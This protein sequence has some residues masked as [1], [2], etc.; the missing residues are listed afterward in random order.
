M[1]TFIYRKLKHLLFHLRFLTP[2]PPSAVP[3]SLPLV[4]IP[5]PPASSS[6]SPAVVAVPIVVEPVVKVP[7]P[8][9]HAPA[10]L[11]VA[12]PCPPS[13]EGPEL[14]C[15]AVDAR[16]LAL[17]GRAGGQAPA[18]A[19]V[20]AVEVGVDVGALGQQAVG[21]AGRAHGDEGGAGDAAGKAADLGREA[22][23]DWKKDVCS[24]VEIDFERH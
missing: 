24:G 16:L 18:V 11:E 5:V 6:P 12:V 10:P 13:P 19:D 7:R 21:V 15:V 2:P 1:I 22:W 9:P 3:A 4:P 17:V 14:A 20:V 23:L 8:R